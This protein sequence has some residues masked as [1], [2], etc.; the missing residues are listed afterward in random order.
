[1]ENADYDKTLFFRVGTTYFK[2][3]NK[4]LISGDKIEVHKPWNLETI[5]QDYPE[6]WKIVLKNMERFDGM[7]TLP[8]HINYQRA[9]NN[10]L[11]NYEP[12]PQQPSP[13]SWDYIENFLKHIFGEQYV[14]GLDY[15][16]ILYR[17]P[18]QILPILALI[19]KERNTGKTTFLKLL[20]K[21]FGGNMTFN[22]LSDIRSSFN[23]DW[24]SK[25]IIGIE[26]ALNSDNVQ[27][28]EKIKNLNTAINF[29]L[30]SK[31]IDRIEIEFFAKF[32]MCS[33]NETKF[34]IIDPHE[35]RYWVRQIPTLSKVIPDMLEFMTKEIPAFLHFLLLRQIVSVKITRM[36]F[37][38]EQIQTA[39]LKKIKAQYVNQLELEFC[40]ILVE[41]MENNSLSEFAFT[42]TDLK[43]LFEREGFKV[44]RT[45]ISQ[46]LNEQ[47]QLVQNPI[48]STY[49]TYRYEANGILKEHKVKGR[50]YKITRAELNEKSHQMLTF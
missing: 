44:S 16:T 14:L 46:L 40:Q 34:A 45:K 17:N 43:F 18:V 23:S 2:R 4:P 10:F 47:W 1:M 24:A 35:T 26:E 13:G 7:C 8:D 25:L 21:I 39:A 5:K 27:D 41:I 37:A 38:P 11:N 31:G 6:N 20:K 22:T 33:N 28:S 30:E 48:A 32:I 19:S 36:W 9:S 50:Y 15:I 29:K 49:I 3:V 42:N 12:I